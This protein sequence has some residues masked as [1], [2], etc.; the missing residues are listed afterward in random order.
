MK[1]T[2]KAISEK[3]RNLINKIKGLKNVKIDDINIVCFALAIITFIITCFL[4]KHFF[5]IQKSKIVVYRLVRILEFIVIC[6]F[7]YFIFNLFRKLKNKDEK[8]IEFAKYFFTYFAIMLFFTVLTWPGIFKSDEF[9][10]LPGIPLLNIR[11]DQ[12]YLLS[13][14]YMIAMMIYP[15]M[16][17]ITIM[18]IFMI[19][20]MVAYMLVKVGKLFKNKKIVWLFFIPLLFLPV[21]DN[22]L[23]PL[24]NSTITYLFLLLILKLLLIWKAGNVTKKDYIS[25][26][27]LTAVMGAVKTEYLYLSIVVPILM[28]FVFKIGW[29]KML[30]SIV[31]MFM[32]AKIINIPQ[33]D[34]ECNVYILTSVFNPLQYIICSERANISQEDIDV[35][36]TITNYN[37]LQQYE[38]EMKEKPFVNILGYFPGYTKK[39]ATSEEKK[40]FLITYAKIVL[41]NFDIFLEGRMTTFLYTSGMKKDFINHVGYEEPNYVL[42]LE[43]NGG[44]F[45]KGYMKTN[46]PLLSQELREKNIKFIA[47][48][49]SKDYEKTNILYPIFYNI[50]PQIFILLG[51][52]IYALIKK[53]R[54]LYSIIGMCLLLVVLVF[55][56]AP[57]TF[58]MYYMPFYMVAN[59]I[60][61]YIIISKIERR[62]TNEH[63]NNDGRNGEKV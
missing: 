57:G 7:W 26:I 50:I 61:A 44:L 62:H 1:E 6:G 5:I 40:N 32:L 29:K 19:S 12:H 47:C 52:G 16:A 22:N 54:F 56:T 58:W 49:D 3:G 43:N 53:N 11:Y 14:F 15:A 27:I 25:I 35:I 23:F 60:I 17:V 38:K 20:I 9:Y 24:R 28:W 39:I 18:Q 8:A 51:M 48:R 4:S 21:I 34:P 30:I 10:T 42:K 2:K 31:S 55:L 13:I 59:M 41:K 46:N 33:H 37:R 63:S 36:N 45:T